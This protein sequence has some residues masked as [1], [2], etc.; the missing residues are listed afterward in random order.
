MNGGYKTMPNFS[1]HDKGA[2]E[3]AM[4]KLFKVD[5]QYLQTEAMRKWMNDA[6][7][8][9]VE[10]DGQLPGESAKQRDR[11]MEDHQVYQGDIGRLTKTLRN[12]PSAESTMTKWELVFFYYNEIMDVQSVITQAQEEVVFNDDKTNPVEVPHTEELP[13]SQSSS[14]EDTSTAVVDSTPIQT[15]EDVAP[16]MEEPTVIEEP[17]V[18]TSQDAQP[19]VDVIA[20]EAT[21][22]ESIKTETTEPVPTGSVEVHSEQPYLNNSIKE[23]NT[24]EIKMDQLNDLMNAAVAPAAP[25]NA[26][27]VTKPT[28]AAKI[29][30]EDQDRVIRVLADS[31]VRRDEYVKGHQVTKVISKQKPAALRALQ[32]TGT[33]FKADDYKDEAK[34]TQKLNE[35][36]NSILCKFTGKP[37]MTIEV[38]ETLS[39]DQKFAQV[40]T[41]VDQDAIAKARAIYELAKQVKANP[42]MSIDAVITSAADASYAVKGVVLEGTPFTMEELI[43]KILDNTTGGLYGVDQCD[44]NGAPIENATTFKVAVVTTNAK[45]AAD[46]ISNNKKQ[47]KKLAVKIAHKKEFIKGGE[48]VQ[49]IFDQIDN[50]GKQNSASFKAA[51]SINGVIVPAGVSCYKVDD[52]GKRIQSSTRTVKGQEVVTYKTVQ[53]N[54][55]VSVPVA[56]VV[57]EMG[58]EYKGGADAA[59]DFS[60]WGLQMR[61]EKAAANVLTGGESVA[62][63]AGFGVFASLLAGDIALTESVAGSEAVKAL[64]AASDAAAAKTAAETAD[65]LA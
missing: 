33:T 46:T 62:S 9:L 26:E 12:L 59:L 50:T 22:E 1:K 17:V 18:S 54:W 52:E 21:H 4:R 49:Y 5:K 3:A 64:K 65:D 44:A 27:T 32:T 11:R 14:T 7:V 10:Y 31:R 55:N 57:N 2:M 41:D 51:I 61:T 13:N 38:F 43:I 53:A 29:S 24:E 45:A 36:I 6:P 39:D 16:I 34:M 60:R 48:R 23:N 20:H 30:R 42:Q 25:A 19:S 56:A 47:Q 63:M 8:A 58:A 37:N 28:K 35:R 15:Q 40:K